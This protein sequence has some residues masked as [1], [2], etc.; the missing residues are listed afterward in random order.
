MA[1]LTF[2][3]KGRATSVKTLLYNV[4]LSDAELDIEIL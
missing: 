4:S 3:K 1:K 2:L